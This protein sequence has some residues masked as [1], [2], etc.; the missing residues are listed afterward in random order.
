[1]PITYSIDLSVGVV[2]EEWS[3]TVSIDEI[4]EHWTTVLSNP[5]AQRCRR[6]LADLR[7]LE[8]HL[9]WSEV[10]AV[11]NDVLVRM[12]GP[13]G[14]RVAEVVSADV[15]YGRVMQFKAAAEQVSS[16]AIFWNYDEALAWITRPVQPAQ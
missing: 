11:A 15:Q 13:E 9:S 5:D 3:G 10:R 1:M 7:R 8:V 12:I 2:F 4:R 14:W 16:H 6:T